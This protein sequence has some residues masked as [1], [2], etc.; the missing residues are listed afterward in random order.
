MV[1]YWGGIVSCQTIGL[2]LNMF[3]GV[4]IGDEPLRFSYIWSDNKTAQIF[5]VTYNERI[6]EADNH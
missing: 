3:A 4:N 1:K 6:S 5:T 2:K